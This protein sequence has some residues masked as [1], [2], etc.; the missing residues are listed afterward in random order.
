[1]QEKNF[2]THLEQIEGDTYLKIVNFAVPLTGD[3]KSFDVKLPADSDPL[4]F[5]TATTGMIETI[6]NMAKDNTA[7]GYLYGNP[8]HLFR[9]SNPF[10]CKP[11]ERVYITE[12]LR[13]DGKPEYIVTKHRISQGQNNFVNVGYIVGKEKVV[14]LIIDMITGEHKWF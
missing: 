13:I 8:K 11:G 12:H 7:H 2:S 14:R 1:M 10:G 5:Y 9:V 3:K 4:V 6:G